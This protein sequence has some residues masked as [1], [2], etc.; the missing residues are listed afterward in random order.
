MTKKINI[1]PAALSMAVLISCS[2]SASETEE[3]SS[4]NTENR[5]ETVLTLSC[6]NIDPDV[7]R[8]VWIDP[9]FG[10]ELYLPA[11]WDVRD[12]SSDE[13][14]ENSGLVYLAESPQKVSGSTYGEVGISVSQVDITDT[15]DIYEALKADDNYD[16]LYYCDVNGIAS[17]G[18]E[19]T[20]YNTAGLVFGDENGNLYTIAIS[21]QGSE[22]FNPSAQNIIQSVR[23]SSGGEDAA[24]ATFLN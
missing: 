15:S 10:F 2:S 13:E 9:G 11:N 23:P 4:E 1:L 5:D 22:T 17:I 8:G 18:F 19:S 3:A 7:Y 16:Y 24:S 14:Y 6:K 20:A 12:V 21:P